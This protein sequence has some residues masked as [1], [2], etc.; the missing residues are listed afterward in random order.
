MGRQTG[1]KMD[2]IDPTLTQREIKKKYRGILDRSQNRIQNRT[3]K[4][5]DQKWST[6]LRNTSDLIKPPSDQ[7][8]NNNS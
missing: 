5:L 8:I 7:F 6:H 3:H 2:N 1:A 4:D